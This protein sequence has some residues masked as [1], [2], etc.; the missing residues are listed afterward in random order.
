LLGALLLALVV[1]PASANI[2]TYYTSP[3]ATVS[4]Q[5]TQ[6]L[7]AKVVFNISNGS[8]VVTVTNLETDVV[9]VGQN[10]SSLLFT[11]SAPNSLNL[12]HAT[13]MISTPLGSGLIDVSAG[14]VVS[15][16]TPSSLNTTVG[17]SASS[18][19]HWTTDT[20]QT[21]GKTMFLNDL[22]G[23]GQPHQTIIGQA[24]S[25]GDYSNANSSITNSNTNS[26]NPFIQSTAQ[27][28]IASAGILSTDSLKSV[29]LGFGTGGCDTIPLYRK[30]PEPGTLA[31]F[32][33]GAIATRVVSRKR[34]KTL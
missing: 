25:G 31:L 4:G 21:S 16:A 6:G 24:E 29:Q 20:S 27:F 12:A 1:T 2:Y 10:I 13:T 22:N 11:L 34:S 9:S 5:P 15:A 18:T 30:V 23:G 14:G 3:T 33:I 28:N 8:M 17:T 7:D 32:M 26:H 19:T